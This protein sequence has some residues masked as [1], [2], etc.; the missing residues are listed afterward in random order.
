[1]LRPLNHSV[2]SLMHSSGH[3]GE[4]HGKGHSCKAKERRIGGA[5]AEQF[6]TFG[7]AEFICIIFVLNPG[8]S[9]SELSSE[10]RWKSPRCTDTKRQAALLFLGLQGR[11]L[12]M[13]A[14]CPHREGVFQK[15]PFEAS[16]PPATELPLQRPG[17]ARP[18]QAAS[19]LP[20]S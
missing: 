16:L 18:A 1:M 11:E 8:T 5:K 12:Q 3:T 9:A 15:S 4:D 6:G 7:H 13:L 17:V 10:R 14:S 19:F 20:C 2:N